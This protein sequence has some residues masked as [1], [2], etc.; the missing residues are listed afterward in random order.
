MT[1]DIRI[2]SE[3]AELGAS[4]TGYVTYEPSPG[5]PDRRIRGIEFELQWTMGE[6]NDNDEATFE[7]TR[8]ECDA[9]GRL[10]TIWVVPVPHDQPISYDGHL[11]AVTWQ[12][13]ATLDVRRGRDEHW[14]QEVVVIP[15]NGRLVYDGPH[16]LRSER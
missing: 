16:P 5:E 13:K 3:I 8:I 7:P 11:F 15:R 9:D 10:D 4:F 6:H 14:T 1:P 2:D 12:L